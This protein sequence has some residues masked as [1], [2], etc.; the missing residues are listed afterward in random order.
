MPQLDEVRASRG[1][2]SVEDGAVAVDK[3]LV[4]VLREAKA[5]KEADFASKWKTMKTGETGSATGL[6]DHLPHLMC[7]GVACVSS[8]YSR[9]PLGPLKVYSPC[10]CQAHHSYHWCCGVVV[11]VI[12]TDTRAPTRCLVHL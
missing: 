1:K 3:P 4:E 11:V 7:P 10:P 6:S 9:R 8:R 12:S 2:G 5:A